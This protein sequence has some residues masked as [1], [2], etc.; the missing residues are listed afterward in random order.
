LEN[1]KVKK[2]WGSSSS[3]STSTGRAS[4]HVGQRAAL[5]SG[6]GIGVQK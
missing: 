1:L 5:I 4:L 3:S 6:G 2:N